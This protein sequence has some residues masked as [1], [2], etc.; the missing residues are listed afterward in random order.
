MLKQRKCEL[1]YFT[2]IY[3][4]TKEFELKAKS[5]GHQQWQYDKLFEER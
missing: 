5:F 2:K 1:S 4:F 3:K